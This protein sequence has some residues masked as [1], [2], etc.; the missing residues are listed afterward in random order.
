MKRFWLFIALVIGSF[1]QMTQGLCAKD[2]VPE[3][4]YRI[5][6][7][8]FNEAEYEAAE[9]KFSIVIQKGDLSIPEAAAYVV[10]SY[11][12]RASCRIEQG[13]KLKESKKLS[14]ALDKYDRA[15]DDLSVFKRRFEELQETLKSD[16]LYEEIEKHFVIISEQMVQLAGEAGDICFDQ[17]KYEKA[18]EWYDKGLQ[19]IDLR[20]STY[21]DLLYAK[22]NS[23]FQLNR[24]EEALRLLNKFQGELSGHKLASNAL[25]YA[26]DI[27]RMMADSKDEEINLEKACDA[28]GQVVTGHIEGADVDLVK[29]ALLQK[30]RCEK[31]LGRMDEALADFR[32]ILTYYPNTQ[33]EVDAS[34]EIGEYSYL[35]KRYNSAI[36]SFDRVITVAKSLDL[37][38]RMAIS[39]YWIGWS[40]SSE[41]DRIDTESSP[42]MI[43]RRKNLYEESIDAFRNSVKS[44]EKFWK[45]QGREVQMA[46]ELEHRYYG[47]SLFRI[48]K[49]YQKLEKWDDAI[50]AFEKIPRV[51]KEWWLKGLAEIAVSE[52]GKGNL[53]ASLTRWNELKRE[54][55]LAKVPDIELDLLMRR[56]ESIFFVLE[57]YAESEKA[58]REI[59]AKYPDFPNEPEARINLALSLFKQ[60]KS[61]DAIQE[62][63]ILLDKYGKDDSLGAS[64]GEALFWRGYLSP[65]QA[66]ERSEGTEAEKEFATNIERAIKDYRELVT[67]FPDHPRA[68]DAQYEIGFSIYSL[69]AS[70]EKKYSEA[71]VEYSKV[72]ENYPESE[73]SDDALFDIGRCYGL[74]ED[75][76]N[77]EKFLQQLVQDYPTS[78]LA[79]DALRLVAEIHFERAQKESSDS[80]T[81]ERQIA[82][83][84]YAQIIS[85]YPD[86]ESEAVAHF[87]IGAM[88]YKFE[89]DL[90]KA[91]MEFAKCAEVIEGL[92]DRV[93]AG[94][95]VPVDLDVATI[96]NLLLK[97]TF[98]QAESMFQM[99]KQNEDQ[100]QP[101]E[102]VKQS[103]AQARSIYQ[104]S[105]T[106]GTRLRSDFPETTQNLYSIM[107]GEKLDIPIIGEAQYMVSRCL[108]K[109]GDMEGA[110]AGL[111]SIKAPE[112]LRLK[113]EYLLAHIAYKQGK[114]DDAR[115]MAEN[116][117]NNDVVQD[118]A[119][120]YNV[121]IQVLLANIALDSGN[122]AEAKAQALDTW[123]L[124]QSVI[125]LWEESAYIVAKC[126]QQQN[127]VEKAR[128]WF[129]KLQDSALERWRV[130]GQNAISQL[131]GQ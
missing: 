105:L 41:A 76:I 86:T 130:V 23:V 70:D 61:R 34:L 104:Q 72:L 40:Y 81:R 91:A 24:Y 121:G 22:A 125:G 46:K 37:P 103:Y 89:D 28:Y 57:R 69:G 116:W 122:I 73:Y 51:Y 115:T 55:S 20:T 77:E 85:R 43:K 82:E 49:G 58:Y 6:V 119:D 123:A 33:F 56:A 129:G 87:Q 25:F 62:F 38:D 99:A 95:Y 21:G 2:D 12:G 10:N 114:L 59:I 120:E 53:E 27:Y 101:S 111:Q 42:D 90:N 118:M 36:E 113:A 79:D 15:Y 54:I 92:L 96:A 17:G 64:I 26:G 66:L 29:M 3:R 19:F 8:L 75:E 39:Y 100:A 65:R 71:I 4:D 18:I 32:T 93:I 80:A 110:R 83:D 106:R 9:S 128:S 127:D 11:Y 35:A 52:E 63:T 94:E 84:T 126:Y 74:L 7:V 124:F 117:L 131:E 97:S 109:E 112:K 48:G 67:R 50:E 13:R 31:K 108:Y 16:A 1:M 30:G 88:F 102:V 98:W 47:E 68:D 14:E 78:E 5:A 60:D 107:G 44:S 45:K